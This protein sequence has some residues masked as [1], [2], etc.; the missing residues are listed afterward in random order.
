MCSASRGICDR[1]LRILPGD[2]LDQLQP[3]AIRQAHVGQA[4]VR[5]FG[6][7]QVLCLA[8]RRCQVCVDVHARE[9]DIQQFEDI[10]FVIDDQGS[11]FD[12]LVHGLG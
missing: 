10:G 6:G 11:G 4:E 12:G 3:A 2:L 7:E 9:G 5:L 1:D 8:E